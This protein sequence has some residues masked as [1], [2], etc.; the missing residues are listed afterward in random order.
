VQLDRFDGVSYRDALTTF[1][2]FLLAAI[3]ALVGDAFYQRDWVLWAG[4]FWLVA[5]TVA[6]FSFVVFWKRIQITN[7]KY[8]RSDA[9]DD[10]PEPR[11]AA[12]PLRAVIDYGRGST[13][14]VQLSSLPGTVNWQ[15]LADFLTENHVST[16][17]R[18]RVQPT[19]GEAF[20]AMKKDLQRLR[21][22]PDNGQITDA[23][24]SSAV[25]NAASQIANGR[26]VYVRASAE[27]TPPD[28]PEGGRRRQNAPSDPP[29]RNFR[30]RVGE[31]P[32]WVQ[33]L[34]VLLMGAVIAYGLYGFFPMQS[35]EFARA[36]MMFTTRLNTLPVSGNTAITFTSDAPLSAGPIG[37]VSGQCE[38]KD[39]LFFIGSVA[40]VDS[41]KLSCSMT[42]W[43]SA[44]CRPLGD[45]TGLYAVTIAVTDDAPVAVQHIRTHNQ[46]CGVA[47]QVTTVEIYE[48][49][50]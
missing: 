18:A 46:Y 39:K 11:T 3:V 2:L 33:V 25:Q 49:R 10:T 45:T 12:T 29:D 21:L 43:N 4:A 42:N 41:G 20:S 17:T 15:R 27:I 32:T 37:S 16:A 44:M 24:S 30:V 14:Y 28:P 36:E 31:L 48:V 38:Y 35:A 6:V 5:F 47:E 26:P 7:E 19:S 34:I 40:D 1:A 23:Y 8:L 50:K 22:V 9:P 13:E